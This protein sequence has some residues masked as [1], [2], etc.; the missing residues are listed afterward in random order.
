[1]AMARVAKDFDKCMK[2]AGSVQSDCSLCTLMKEV[3]LEIGA[4]GDEH[5]S[6][7]WKIQACSLLALLDNSLKESDHA[8]TA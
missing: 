6:I 5:G 1:M 7:V 8:P 4:P 2:E 3:T